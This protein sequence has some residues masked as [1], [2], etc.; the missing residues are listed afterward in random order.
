MDEKNSSKSDIIRHALEVSG[1][2]LDEVLMIGDRHHDI[3]GAKANNIASA[4]VLYGYGNREEH[5]NA[6][7]DYIIDK[8]SELLGFV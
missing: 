4:G 1:A 2:P 6:G 8:P 5:V 3:D 7:A